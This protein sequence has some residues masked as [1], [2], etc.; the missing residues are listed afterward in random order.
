MNVSESINWQPLTA[1]QLDGRRFIA[2]TWSGSVIDS[3]LT[4]HHIGPMTVMTDPD[5]QIPVI[6]IGAPTQPNT[7]GLTL[8]SINVLRERS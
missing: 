4:I 5:F 3:R 6:L 7:L 1:E 8:R 2:R